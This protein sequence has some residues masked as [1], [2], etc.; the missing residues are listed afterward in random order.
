MNTMNLI[1]EGP[2]RVGKGSLI[3]ELTRLSRIECGVFI[4]A[5]M[6]AD[7][8]THHFGFPP[9]EG[10]D[11]DKMFYQRGAF[12]TAMDWICGLNRVNISVL[13]DR[14]WIGERIFGPMYRGYHPDP[15]L[16]SIE[17]EKIPQMAPTYM[18]RLRCSYDCVVE[19]HARS[20]DVRPL[21]SRHAWDR[22]CSD[23]EQA[24]EMSYIQSPYVLDL[25]TSNA[26]PTE[27]A[28]SV[29]TFLFQSE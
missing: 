12:D 1:V 17:N 3:A 18:V 5:G 2:T 6:F 20:M 21:L 10:D 27:L 11:H 16:R 15:R 7:A 8:F 19:R 23:Y 9:P 14:C 22:L 26:S 24:Y 29:E 13:L 28:E 4:R 25:D